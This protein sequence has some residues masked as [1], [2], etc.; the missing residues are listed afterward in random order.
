MSTRAVKFL[1]QKGA[2]FEVVK[3]RHEQKGAMFAA[4]AV[5]FPLERTIKTLVVSLEKKQYA[6]ALVPGNLQLDLKKMAKACDAKRAK[7]ADTTTAERLTGYHVGGISPFGI[8]GRLPAVMEAALLDHDA[9]MINAGQR[10]VMLKMSPADI[11]SLLDGA[12]KDLSVKQA[13]A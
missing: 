12:I 4:R 5:G 13:M 10:G 7:M 11:A 2:L 9:V 6:L 1:Q 3:Y 8:T